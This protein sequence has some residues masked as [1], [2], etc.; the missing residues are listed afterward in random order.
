M[1]ADL[2][3]FLCNCFVRGEG[4]GVR[5]GRHWVP[6]TIDLSVGGRDLSIVQ[7]PEGL[8]ISAN[9]HDGFLIRTT[10]IVVADVGAEERE[11]VWVLLERLSYLLSF[12]G[13]SEVECYGWDHPQDPP[14]R[15]MHWTTFARARY[16]KPTLAI[17]EAGVVRGYLEGVW[18]EYA[19]VEE[20]R[21]LRRSIDIFTT[22]ET[23]GLP[24]ELK[25]ATIFILLENLKSTHARERA[26]AFK[27]GKWEKPNGDRPGFRPLLEEML[28]G[29]GMNSP[30]LGAV[31][32][33]RNEIIHSGVSELPFEEQEEIYGECQ[34]MARE[35]LL[36]SW[37]YS[38]E[39]R[40]YGGRGMSRK[41]I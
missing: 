2:K 5:V 40:L 15:N 36:R 9:K 24:M 37:G 1:A 7:R 21:D 41:R 14:I 38:G 26:Y 35:Y 17:R 6:N 25:L 16:S 31:V 32:K 8:V 19:R 23:H 39:F 20:Q 18:S 34:D 29:A 4:G 30:D 22:A 12:A 33:L 28:V 11:E 13:C 10:D 27:R 3:A